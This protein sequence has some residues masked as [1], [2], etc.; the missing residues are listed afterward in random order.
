MR[1]IEF[2]VLKNPAYLVVS[3]QFATELLHGHMGSLQPR[4]DG[5]PE[6]AKVNWT[7]VP[8]LCLYHHLPSR[9]WWRYQ[10]KAKIWNRVIM[11]SE[12]CGALIF[13]SST[14]LPVETWKCKFPRPVKGRYVQDLSHIYVRKLLI[15]WSSKS[16]VLYCGGKWVCI[17]WRIKIGV[18]N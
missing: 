9:G 17:T 12:S 5:Q 14:N 16:R 18:N 11:V 6:V 2:H 13:H 1:H 4:L 10:I 15:A 7:F 3:V 8:V